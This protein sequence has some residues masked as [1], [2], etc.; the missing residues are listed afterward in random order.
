MARYFLAPIDFWGRPDEAVSPKQDGSLPLR[1]QDDPGLPLPEP[2]HMLTIMGPF[3]KAHHS[4]G[5]S[6]GVEVIVVRPPEDELNPFDLPI[7]Y[8][9]RN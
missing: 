1:L 2:G 5:R 9:R 3:F 7:V 8:I 6:L 4:G